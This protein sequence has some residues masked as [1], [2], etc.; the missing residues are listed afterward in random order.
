MPA[1]AA[2]QVLEHGADLDPRRRLAGAQEDCRRL[3]ALDM[4]DAL[5]REAP[6]VAIGV[7]QRQLLVAV[8]RV[9]G[10]VDVQRERRRSPYA[11]VHRLF[12]THRAPDSADFEKSDDI[13]RSGE[14][15]CVRGGRHLA[16]EEMQWHGVDAGGEELDE[17]G[18]AVIAATSSAA[19]SI[20]G[21]GRLAHVSGRR[22]S[23]DEKAGCGH[24]GSPF[25]SQGSQSLG[26]GWARNTQFASRPP[27]LTRFI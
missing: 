3:A 10:V 24:P 14:N 1:D 23:G 2:G 9:A 15:L 5:R 7:E 16:R 4:V 27:K 20:R 18:P 17:A 22:V 11:A 12:S 19:I 21:S 26:T 13:Q 25:G 8:H 6:P